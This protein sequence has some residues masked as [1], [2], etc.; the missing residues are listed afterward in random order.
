MCQ[1]KMYKFWRVSLKRE[2]YVLCCIVLS[3]KSIVCVISYESVLYNKIV[4]INQSLYAFLM[5]VSKVLYSKF[6]F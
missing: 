1:E 4:N 3:N 5:D 2:W 6:L